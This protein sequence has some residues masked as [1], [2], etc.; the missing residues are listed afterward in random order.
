MS[1]WGD[2]DE[3]WSFEDDLL[4]T[5]DSRVGALQQPFAQPE[6]VM[7]ARRSGLHGCRGAPG[8]DR[9][10]LASKQQW[11]DWHWSYS[12]RGLLEQL[13]PDTLNAYRDDCF[14]EMDAL[15]TAAGYPL[16]LNALMVTGRA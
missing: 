7:D 9:G 10:L 16:R 14:R 13:A 3:R 12:V 4:P 1:T 5:S 8:G 6:Q 15:Q 11:W 2:E